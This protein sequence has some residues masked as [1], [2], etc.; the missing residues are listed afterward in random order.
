MVLYVL[1]FIC[2]YFLVSK[3]FVSFKNT[4]DLRVVW[5]VRSSLLDLYLVNATSSI[6]LLNCDS[7]N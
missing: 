2:Q 6:W 3:S 1:A 5:D 4:V 7:M